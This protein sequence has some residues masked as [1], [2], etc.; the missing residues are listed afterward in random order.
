MKY[1]VATRA[2][3]CICGKFVSWSNVALSVF[4]PDDEDSKEDFECV[5]NDC[6]DE[7]KELE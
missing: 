5:C 2:K 4:A 3:C 6:T 7:D 1:D